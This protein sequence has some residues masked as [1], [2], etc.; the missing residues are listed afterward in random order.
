M[1]WKRHHLFFLPRVALPLQSK[2]SSSVLP[3]QQEHLESTLFFT[4]G[5]MLIGLSSLK[6][7]LNKSTD[8]RVEAPKKKI[9]PG[10][11]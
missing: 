11:S 9:C 2:H 5:D 7:V 6:G 4:L 10:F 1:R 8:T 3:H